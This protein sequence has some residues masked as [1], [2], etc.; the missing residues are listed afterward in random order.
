[1]TSYRQKNCIRLCLQRFIKDSCGCVDPK[2]PNIYRDI[3]YC[4]SLSQLDCVSQSRIKYLKTADHCNECPFECDSVDYQ[5]RTSRSRYPTTYYTNYLRYQTDLVS[6]FPVTT[7]V[8]DNHIQKNI[9]L[10]NVF[11]DDLA[12]KYVKEIPEVSP[13][14]LF[15]TIGGNLGLFLGFSC[16][17]LLLTLIKRMVY[18]A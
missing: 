2:L 15:G 13:D 17:S 5:I 6:R 16:L 8:T 11:Y 18:K 14:A 4:A 7:V 3:P 9:V 12:T 1:M 10:L